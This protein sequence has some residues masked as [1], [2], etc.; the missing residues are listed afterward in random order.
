MDD[1][2]LPTPALTSGDI[3]LSD[4]KLYSKKIGPS[5]T[6]GQNPIGI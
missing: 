2:S 3:P 6:A 1:A 4:F 5:R